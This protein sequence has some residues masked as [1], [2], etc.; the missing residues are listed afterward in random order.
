MDFEE[1]SLDRRLLTPLSHQGL[2]RA[3][4]IQRQAIPIAMQ[5]KDIIA[6]SKTG[7][8]K[9]LAFLLPAMQRVLKQRALSK[10]DARV[11][12]LTPTRELAKQVYAQLRLLVAGTGVKATLIV[13]G[14]NF[15]DQAKQLV[16]DPQFIVGTPGRIADHLSQRQIHLNGLE[17]LILDEADRMLDLGFADQLLQINRAADHRLRQTL[18]F[19]ATLDNTEVNSIAKQLLKAPV[20]VAIGGANDEHKDI[21][22]R[23]IL[24]DN[25]DHKKALL[26]HVIKGEPISQM[27][28]FT[29]T[30]ADTLTLA[31]YITEQGLSCAALSG[32]MNQGKRNQIMDGFSRGQQQVLVTTDIAS[33]GL[34]LVNVSHV[35]NFD[36]P[37]HAE[38]YVHRI[39]R[40][41]RAGAKGSAL[42]LVGPKDWL[43]FQAVEAYLNQAISFDSIAGMEAKFKGFSQTTSAPKVRKA[44]QSKQGK[45]QTKRK[46]IKRV[47]KT[48][49]QG[50]DVGDAPM[51]RK[52]KP[53]TSDE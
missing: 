45:A 7:S 17:M 44:S 24:C 53:P 1:F 5:G 29:A 20:R 32:D 38:E 40:T 21:Q 31:D 6:S 19:S 33:R 50:I 46:P 26:S 23:F 10:R 39:G 52:P 27:I 49:Q 14:E 43:N 30:R 48:F 28:V 11:L 12:I 42:S 35:I 16:K 41:G 37:K 22:Q 51:R 9:T 13:G 8:G 4:D 36:M 3:T 47:N 15:N 18:M 34:D 2:T 25:L